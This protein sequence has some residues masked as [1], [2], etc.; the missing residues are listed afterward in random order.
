M[1]L[2]KNIRGELYH[3][4]TGMWPSPSSTPHG[5]LL[6]CRTDANKEY[7]SGSNCSPC[8]YIRA[9]SLTPNENLRPKYENS[10]LKM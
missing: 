2:F 8:I 10:C 4:A 3:C 1:H 6:H 7:H 9:A 5:S